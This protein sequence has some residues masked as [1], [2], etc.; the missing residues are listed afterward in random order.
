MFCPG[1]IGGNGGGGGVQGGGGG[2]GEGPTMNYDINAVENFTMVNHIRRDREIGEYSPAQLMD[3]D[4]DGVKVYKYCV[5]LQLEM[6]FTI[7]RK[8]THSQDVIW[9][10][11]HR[12]LTACGTGPLRPILEV[13]SF[14]CMDLPGLENRRLHSLSARI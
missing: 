11:G 9:R 14:G 1:G 8:D 13:L 5:M 12:F 10:R 6:L 4:Q 7:Q 2:V 3:D